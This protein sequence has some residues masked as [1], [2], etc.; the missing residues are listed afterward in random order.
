MHRGTAF[1]H[2]H[3]LIRLIS[4]DSDTFSR[5]GTFT[6]S[7]AQV[8]VRNRQLH[9]QI[10]SNACSFNT[11]W[12]RILQPHVFLTSRQLLNG[13]IK[14]L[15]GKLSPASCS[16]LNDG[17]TL[18]WS[19]ILYNHNTLFRIDRRTYFSVQLKSLAIRLSICYMVGLLILSPTLN[20][21]YFDDFVCQQKHKHDISPIRWGK[22]L[23]LS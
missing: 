16:N 15:R 10:G 14:G 11:D 21:S 9:T 23:N 7:L 18:R 8:S 6:P 17:F 12:L 13:D 22:E 19:D 2:I 5:H 4:G 3:I 1:N 20:F